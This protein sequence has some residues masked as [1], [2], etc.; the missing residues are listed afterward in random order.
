MEIRLLG[1]LKTV[2]SAPFG[3]HNYFAWPTA[4]RLKNGHVAVGASGFRLEHICPFGKAVLSFSTDECE[5]FSLPAPVIDTPLDDRDCGLC[6]FGDSSLIVTSFNNTA[7]FQR[8]CHPDDP[9]IN[10]YLDTVTAEEEQRFLGSVFRISHDNGQTF[11]P[12]YKSPVTS[13]HGPCVL[14]DGSLLWVGRGFDK[15]LAHEPGT[16]G[17]EARRIFPDGTN[18]YVGSIEN[19]TVNGIAPL[20][21]EPHAIVLDNGDILCHIRAEAYG[22]NRMFTTLQCV[23]HDNGR[24]WTRPEPLLGQTGG[25]PAHLLKHSSGDILSVYGYREA[26]FGIKVMISR[27]GGE[28]W[29]TGLDLHVNGV[30]DDLGYP[31]TVELADGTLFTV[32]Y[33][34]EKENTPAVILGQRWTYSD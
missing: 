4:V 11:G 25:A 28:S 23:S 14:P 31:A 16:E 2:M 33:A 20:L 1:E 6:A 13:P 30:E 22:E 15:A 3:K 10:A 27:D 5:T 21:C 9:Y 19:V 8:G 17:I 24:T 32:F 12:L 29:M 18:E 26:P 34:H 7:A